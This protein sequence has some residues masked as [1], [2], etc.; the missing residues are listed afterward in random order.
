MYHANS[1]PGQGC[2]RNRSPRAQKFCW[3]A[4]GTPDF[5]EPAAEGTELKIPSGNSVDIAVNNKY[6]PVLDIDFPDPTIINVNGTYYAYATQ[7]NYNGKMNNI[8]IAS[9][10]D[11]FN[12][13]YEGDALPQKPVWANHTQDFWAPH[14][15]YDSSISQYVMFYCAKSNDTALDKCIGVAFADKPLGPFIDKG[16]PLIEGKGFSEIDPMAM[17]DPK[18]G[19]KLLYWGS[20]FAPV[21][22]R[23]LS[24]DWKSFK[25]GSTAKP[26]VFPGNEKN[27]TALIEGAWVDY[28]DGKYYLYYSGDNCCGSK[29]NYAVMVAKADSAT[30]PFKTLGEVNGTRN[31]VIL[32]KDSM[33]LAPGHNSIVKD[34]KGK[35]WITYHAIWKDKDKAGNPSGTDRYLK[36]S[37]L[38]QS[39]RV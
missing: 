36:R 23:E 29:A 31:S 16:T 4:D 11:L 18:T 25:E 2:G 28:F 32:E 17:T 26:V 10:K 5:G 39:L 38:Y 14:V 33:W 9:S 34:S 12:W 22:V 13:K 27:Y 8:Q 35:T 15:L 24:N 37:L 21:R 3:N 1:K 30:G 20:G 7:A 6:N 19:K